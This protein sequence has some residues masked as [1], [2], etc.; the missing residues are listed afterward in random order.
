MLS[1]LNKILG[2]IAKCDD[3]K[4]SRVR[5][6]HQDSKA[7]LWDQNEYV[8]EYFNGYVIAYEL[9]PGLDHTIQTMLPKVRLT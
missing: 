8:N 4:L 7:D 6:A 5:R 1:A 2:D 3:Q 9:D